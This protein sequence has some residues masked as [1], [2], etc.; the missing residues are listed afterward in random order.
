[1]KSLPVVGSKRETSELRKLAH[2]ENE[3]GGEEEMKQ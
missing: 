2:S 3:R 1:M